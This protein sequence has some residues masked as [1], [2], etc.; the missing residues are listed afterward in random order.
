MKLIFLFL[1]TVAIASAGLL[2]GKG[3]GAGLFGGKG[4][5]SVEGTHM[6]ESMDDNHPSGEQFYLVL[7]KSPH[8]QVCR[9][10]MKKEDKN[11]SMTNDSQVQQ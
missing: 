7:Y 8:Q 11:Q 9:R 3:E 4:G 1:T 10:P 6:E 5:G 2:G